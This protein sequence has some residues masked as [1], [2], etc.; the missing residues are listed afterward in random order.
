MDFLGLQRTEKSRSKS[1]A[2]EAQALQHE[3]CNA[4]PKFTFSTICSHY[5][6]DAQMR[7][8]F[9]ES[10]AIAQETWKN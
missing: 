10:F 1:L 2:Y 4:L 7:A 8:Q 6:A 3:N 5:C 9:L